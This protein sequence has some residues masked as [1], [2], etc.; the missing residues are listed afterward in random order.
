MIEAYLTTGRLPSSPLAT[1]EGQDTYIETEVRTKYPFEF[2]QMFS[3]VGA[4]GLVLNL[5]LRLW[6]RFVRVI[7]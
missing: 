5:V 6:H 1:K 3:I 4:L 2:L 7:A